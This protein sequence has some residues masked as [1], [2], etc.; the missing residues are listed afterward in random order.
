M[1]SLVYEVTHNA[2]K[3]EGDEKDNEGAAMRP[4]S[5]GNGQEQQKDKNAKYDPVNRSGRRCH[6]IDK[7]RQKIEL[8]FDGYAPGRSD[9]GIGRCPSQPGVG[10][11]SLHHAQMKEEIPK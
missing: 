11:D 10:N 4:E 3:K 1:K 9:K 8:P 2:D 6:N 7:R 5:E